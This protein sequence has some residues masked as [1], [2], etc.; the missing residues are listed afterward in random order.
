MKSM[1]YSPWN[2][3]K[4]DSKWM[5]T[6]WVKVGVKVGVLCYLVVVM[7]EFV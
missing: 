4:N 2:M 6:V 3:A 5:V 1:G 7:I